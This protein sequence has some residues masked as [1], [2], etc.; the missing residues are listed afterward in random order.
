MASAAGT[1]PFASLPL[2]PAARNFV[3]SDERVTAHRWDV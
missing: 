3:S 2:R 1:M